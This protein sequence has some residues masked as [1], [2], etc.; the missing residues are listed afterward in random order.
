MNSVWMQKL[1][2]YL[3]HD[4][5]FSEVDCIKFKYT[6]EILI[7]DFSKL[8]ILF[9]FFL[10][11][12]QQVLY[13]Y[14]LLALLSIRLFTGGIHYKK[15]TQ[16]LCFTGLFFSSAIFLSLYSPRELWTLTAQALFS[17]LILLFLAPIASPTRPIKSI[18]LY[19]K[20][21]VLG[22]ITSAIHF[23]I[24]Y[25]YNNNPYCICSTWVITLQC[26]QLLFTKGVLHYDTYKNRHQPSC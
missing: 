20:F 16:C 23:A 25:K 22:F 24:A 17:F 5:N 12:K 10:I 7:N 14:C 19:Y 26:I 2:K 9:F 1:H 3:Q 13:L 15:Y 21:K 6:L 18:G 4:L 11:M 8:L